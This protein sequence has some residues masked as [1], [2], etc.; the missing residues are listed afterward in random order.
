MNLPVII[1]NLKTAIKGIAGSGALIVKK[2]APEIMI[3]T[4]LAGFVGTIVQTVKATN[5]SNDILDEKH[6]RIATIEAMHD[7]CSE[8]EYPQEVYQQ[9]LSEAKRR[10]RHGIIR[11]WLPVVTLGGTSMIF[12]LKGYNVLNGRYV[13]TAAAYKGLENLF[14]RYRGNVIDTYG[15]DV[16]YQ[17]MTGIK[18]EELAAAREEQQRNREIEADNKNKKFRKKPVQTAYSQIYNGVFDEYSLRWRREW[19]PDQ[20]LQYLRT[21]ES[22]MN[23][24]VILRG[25]AFVNEAYDKLG[26]DWTVAGQV[27]GWIRPKINGTQPIKKI[28]DFGLDSIP[29]DELRRIL[30]CRRNDEIRIP[31]RMNPHGLIYNLIDEPDRLDDSHLDPVLRPQMQ[32]YQ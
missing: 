10:G 26:L 3:G 28:V 16:D 31:I 14:G 22:E 29:D 6:A 19:T 24:L 5:K 1:S 4:G 15:N 11:A 21:K 27:T 7:N 20:A 18:A 32:Y 9:D 17:M 30:S 8:E 23:D 25:F 12:I 2:H 13:A